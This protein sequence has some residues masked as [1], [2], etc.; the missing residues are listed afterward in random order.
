MLDFLRPV[1]KN[2]SGQAMVSTIVGRKI[3]RV[4]GTFLNGIGAE[5]V[6][7]MIAEDENLLDRIPDERKAELKMMGLPYL[8]VISDLDPFVCYTWLPDEHIEFC[9]SIPK[10]REWVLKQLALIKALLVA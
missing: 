6:R 4:A 8:K 7:K 9:E 10:G 3:G 5:N 2:F 1:T